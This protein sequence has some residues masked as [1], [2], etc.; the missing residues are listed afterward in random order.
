MSDRWKHTNEDTVSKAKASFIAAS[1]PRTLIRACDTS[2]LCLPRRLFLC[3]VV[4]NL[5]AHFPSWR[6]KQGFR[7]SASIGIG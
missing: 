4:F 3:F 6:L 2:E 7:A 5:D 1:N